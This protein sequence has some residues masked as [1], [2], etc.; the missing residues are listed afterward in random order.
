[1]RV[2]AREHDLLLVRQRLGHAGGVTRFL[3]LAKA[4]IARGG[5]ATMIAGP[6]PL[7]GRA[8]ALGVLEAVDWS[9]G[10]SR[11]GERFLAAAAYNRTATLIGCMP[12]TLPMVPALA[13]IAPVHLCVHATPGALSASFAPRLSMSALG[14]ILDALDRS[15]RVLL[16]AASELEAR[17]HEEM[18]GLRTGTLAWVPNGVELPDRSEARAGPIRRVAL[19]SRLVAIKLPHVIAAIDLVAAGRAAGRDVSLEVHGAGPAGAQVRA[20]LDAR[21]PS[22]AW[23]LH[24]TTDRPLEVMRRADVVVGGAR[25]CLEATSVGR[26]A[27]VAQAVGP[28]EAAASVPAGVKGRLGAPVTPAT[29]ELHLADNFRWTRR[30]PVAPAEAWQELEVMPVEDLERV[31]DHVHAKVS[32]AAMLD[33][34]L[35]LLDALG[36]RPEDPAQLSAAAVQRPAGWPSRA[37]EAR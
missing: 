37:G 19:V 7:Q 14:S 34:E 24:G 17:E 32:A 11:D 30:S 5:R 9:S 20:L 28:A 10:A 26:R 18:L 22:D 6:G 16:T 36:R 27:A 8:A 1:M 15:G 31:R 3:A 25:A 4:L 13:R 12:L 33:R 29:L 23:T 2:D 21:L 35:E